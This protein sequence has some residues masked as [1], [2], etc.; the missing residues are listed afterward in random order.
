MM[1][2]LY[3]SENV[4]NMKWRTKNSGGPFNTY[5]FATTVIKPMMFLHQINILKGKT[6]WTDINLVG[7][8]KLYLRNMFIYC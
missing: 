2:L 5:I 8:T 4:I 7:D 3:L 1:I 6:H